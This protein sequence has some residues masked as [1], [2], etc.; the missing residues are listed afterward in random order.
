LKFLRIVEESAGPKLAFDNELWHGHHAYKYRRLSA[1]EAWNCLADRA[2]PTM[3]RDDSPEYAQYLLEQAT[4]FREKV[5]SG[6]PETLKVY[7]DTPAFLKKLQGLSNQELADLY[8][9]RDEKDTNTILAGFHKSTIL[10]MT[11]DEFNAAATYNPQD[12]TSRATRIA[13]KLKQ[14]C[15]YERQLM[16]KD[17][18]PVLITSSSFFQ[19]LTHHTISISLVAKPRRYPSD[20]YFP[21]L[22]SAEVEK[23]LAAYVAK[24]PQRISSPREP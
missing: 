19:Q 7:K 1:C 11:D 6:D 12:P 18:Y 20:P 17:T 3:P 14:F 4:I 10:Y 13:P 8:R 21:N 9:E 23:G 24:Y 16:P 22:P 2:V 5:A 15:S